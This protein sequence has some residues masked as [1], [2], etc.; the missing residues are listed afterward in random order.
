MENKFKNFPIIETILSLHQQIRGRIPCGN[1]SQY[2]QIVIA[3]RSRWL[4][5]LITQKINE[6]RINMSILSKHMVSF[7]VQ[8]SRLTS[9]RV[10]HF[11]A[12]NQS[13][14][15]PYCM[16]RK[17]HTKAYQPISNICMLKIHS[18]QTRNIMGINH[19]ANLL[20]CVHTMLQHPPSPEL[21][22]S[23]KINCG[24]CKC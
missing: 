21:I 22:M 10:N 8:I 13:S 9:P 19:T 2:W 1:V 17:N 6:I 3:R 7:Y 15:Q 12:K 11:K 18:S 14:F 5:L 24:T 4:A 23:S 20:G 16:I